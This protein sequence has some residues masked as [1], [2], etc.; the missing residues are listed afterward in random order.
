MMDSKAAQVEAA[1]RVQPQ[2]WWVARRKVAGSVRDG[3]KWW[4]AVQ[5]RMAAAVERREETR[6]RV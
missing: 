5:R 2:R 6:R 1:M 3:E 4:R